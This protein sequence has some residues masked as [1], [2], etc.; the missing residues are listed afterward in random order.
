M[1]ILLIEIGKLNKAV[2]MILTTQ[3]RNNG[4]VLLSTEVSE[5]EAKGWRE[6][7]IDHKQNKCIRVPLQNAGVSPQPHN[8][9]VDFPSGPQMALEAQ[10]TRSLGGVP[11]HSICTYMSL[12]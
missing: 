6:R 11:K 5:I 9:F 3:Y 12:I 2:G 10:T 4:K 8:C 7:S 1:N